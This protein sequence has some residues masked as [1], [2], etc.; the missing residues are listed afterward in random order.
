MVYTILILSSIIIKGDVQRLE[1]EV[2][3]TNNF[4]TNIQ[5]VYNFIYTLWH[6]LNLFVKI[7]Y[8]ILIVFYGNINGI[9][10]LV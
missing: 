8:R 3:I 4:S 5:D 7:G 1:N 6:S 2:I 10:L 9:I